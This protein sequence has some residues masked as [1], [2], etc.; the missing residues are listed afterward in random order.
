M[1]C[2]CCSVCYTATRRNSTTKNSRIKTLYHD[3]VTVLVMAATVDER[4]AHR[5]YA[6]RCNEKKYEK[7]MTTAEKIIYINTTKSSTTP[8]KERNFFFIFY[9]SKYYKGCLNLLVSFC[10]ESNEQLDVFP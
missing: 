7:K 6:A 1:G 9:V 8:E 4:C 2:D 10:D 5:P 3:V